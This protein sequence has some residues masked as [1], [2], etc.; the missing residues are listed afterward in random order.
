LFVAFTPQE[1]V[2][3]AARAFSDALLEQHLTL[4]Q[5]ATIT[6]LST[7]ELLAESIPSARLNHLRTD[8][9][10]G[11]VVVNWSDLYV[12]LI[13]GPCGT[14]RGVRNLSRAIR[15]AVPNPLRDRLLAP[16]Q[17]GSACSR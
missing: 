17:A 2:S 14:V 9:V 10:P 12:W 4:E 6:G 8:V 13:Q 5:A 11:F 3:A 15:E 1:S 7:D 16:V